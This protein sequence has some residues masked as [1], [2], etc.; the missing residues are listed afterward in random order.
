MAFKVLSCDGGGIRGYLTC[1][2]LKALQD[3]TG[4]L[5]KVDGFFG[6]ST[7]EIWASRDEGTAWRCVARGLPHVYSV[8]VG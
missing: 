6:T 5:D 2:I 1:L 4:F 8:E 7:G 3:E